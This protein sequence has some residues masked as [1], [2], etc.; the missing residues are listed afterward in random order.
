MSGRA[1]RTR[2]HAAARPA[3]FLRRVQPA[4]CITNGSRIPRSASSPSDNGSAVKKASSTPK[5][6]TTGSETPKAD[7]TS[8]AENWEGQMTVAARR[9]VAAASATGAPSSAKRHGAMSNTVRTSG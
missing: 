8:S 1:A 5:G 4:A 9:A 3:R 6:M 7:T 2:V